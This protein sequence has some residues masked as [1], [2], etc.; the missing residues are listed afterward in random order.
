MRVCQFR[1]PPGTLPAKYSNDTPT[2]PGKHHAGVPLRNNPVE[3]CPLHNNGAQ[4]RP[5]VIQCLK[6]LNLA[7]ATLGGACVA[8]GIEG[9]TASAACNSVRVANSEAATHQA[10]NVVNLSAAEV[11]GREFIDQQ[12]NALR[13]DDSVAIFDVFFNRH[14]ILKTRAASRGNKDTQRVTASAL[15]L[16]ERF[17]L[18]DSFIGNGNHPVDPFPRYDERRRIPLYPEQPVYSGY[19]TR[20]I[21]AY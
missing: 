18:L 5:V 9:V 4:M 7:A 19:S 17:Q 8:A 1:H 21:I 12:A 6:V 14:A 3:G 16:E 15:V 2:P 10:V 11:H 13:L 20:L